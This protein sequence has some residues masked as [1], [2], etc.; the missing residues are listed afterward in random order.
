V[1]FSMPEESDAAE[2]GQQYDLLN[3]SPFL[4]SQA[5]R[6]LMGAPGYWRMWDYCRRGV[7]VGDDRVKLE[8]VRLNSGLGTS[9]P[10]WDR[11]LR[12][13]NGRPVT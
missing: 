3:E 7:P 2:S 8:S 6:H 13:L 10:A 4:L 5:H 1:P 11:F 9:R 12:K